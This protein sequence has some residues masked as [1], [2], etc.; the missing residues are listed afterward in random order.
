[1]QDYDTITSNLPKIS[2]IILLGLLLHC[3]LVLALNVEN[4]YLIWK[5]QVN[6]CQ[7]NTSHPL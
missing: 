4:F 5:L 2:L 7:P 1:M 6:N 3:I